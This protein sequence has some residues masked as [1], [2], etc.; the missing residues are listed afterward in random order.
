MSEEV[1]DFGEPLI[2]ESRQVYDRDGKYLFV[3]TADRGSIKAS[4]SLQNDRKYT[5]EIVRRF[6]LLAGFQ[7][8]PQKM[9]KREELVIGLVRA[10]ADKDEGAFRGNL[11][12]LLDSFNGLPV[13]NSIVSFSVERKVDLDEDRWLVISTRYLSLA[14][15]K[16]FLV[17]EQRINPRLGHGLRIV[18]HLI[19]NCVVVE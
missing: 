11:D 10:I 6:N 14:D 13:L 4:E 17:R 12:D 18:R 9:S 1:K 2:S 5:Q 15:A 8:D 16:S 19:S 7:C 3:V